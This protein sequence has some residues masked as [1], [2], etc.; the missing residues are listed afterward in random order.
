MANPL[1]AWLV[2]P[3]FEEE[4]TLA[5]CLDAVDHAA[6]PAG[7]EWGEW[8]VIDDASTDATSAIA[9]GWAD[10]HR[11]RHLKVVTKEHRQ[12][13][14]HSLEQ[15]RQRFLSFAGPDDVLVAIDAD[16]AV[17]TGALVALLAPFV[18]EP[19]LTAAWGI[20]R[21]TGERR[22]R[23]ASTFQMQLV[24]DLASELGPDVARA[25]GCLYAL[26]PQRLPDFA[27]EDGDVVDDLQLSE[28]FG[29]HE[30]LCRSVPEGWRG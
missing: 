3:A 18:V 2:V 25:G 21:P 23:R 8:L 7:V 27:W 19:A 1:K 28:D 22:G 20:S 14:W 6:L 12:G 4:A 11:L 9:K 10:G 29:Y 5:R 30:E 13:K 17:D 16:V 24:H 15:A 26:R